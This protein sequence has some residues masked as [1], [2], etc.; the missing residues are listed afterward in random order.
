MSLGQYETTKVKVL[1][2]LYFFARLVRGAGFLFFLR[3]LLV[4]LYN[5]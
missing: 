4:Y 5:K 2:R 3:K 1:L